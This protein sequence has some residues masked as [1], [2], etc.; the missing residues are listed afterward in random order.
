MEV[1]EGELMYL[2][3]QVGVQMWEKS[4]QRKLLTFLRKGSTASSTTLRT[5]GVRTE[6][7]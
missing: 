7:L 4:F 3:L 6:Y 5:E 1:E 2:E